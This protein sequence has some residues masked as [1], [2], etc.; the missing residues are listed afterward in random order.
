MKNFIAILAF[1]A[2][3]SVDKVEAYKLSHKS[4]QRDDQDAENPSDL[5]EYDFEACTRTFN[6]SQKQILG[7]KTQ[8][9][10]Q[11]DIQDSEQFRVGASYSQNGQDSAPTKYDAHAQ[12]E[13][14]LD[15][16]L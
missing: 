16:L 3:I 9:E 2:V 8:E 7:Q 11:A 12:K 10:Q 4:H 15:K 1:A 14:D 6:R 5:C 13:T